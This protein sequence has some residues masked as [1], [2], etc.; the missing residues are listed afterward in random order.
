LDSFEKDWQRWFPPDKNNKPVR[1]SNRGC[2][3]SSILYIITGIIVLIIILNITKGLYSEWLWFDSLNYSSVFSTVLQTRLTIFFVSAIVFGGF[4]IG[5][6]FLAMRLSPKTEANSFIPWEIVNRSERTFKLSIIIGTL[7]L[8]IIF[9]LVAQAKWQIILQFFNAQPFSLTDPVFFKDISFYIFSLPF[10]NFVR[11]WLMGMFILT[12]L[13][14]CGI[15]LFSYLVQR[16]KFDLS[17]PVL[18][19]ASSLLSCVLALFAWGYW[20]GIWELVFS[21]RGAVFGAG[22]ADIHAQL[23]AQWI[24]LAIVVICI[25]VIIFSAIRRN[26]RLPLYAIGGWIAAT[27]VIGL[28][29][30]MS[31]KITTIEKDRRSMFP[32]QLQMETQA[33]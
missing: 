17:V 23:P 30:P 13:G 28:I 24:L 19:H 7:V 14:S 12:L 1:S 25:F 15:Y 2:A 8:S 27:I 20:L 18:V 9:G 21:T 4:L 33:G 26:L 32:A 22:Y 3:L 31:L 10:F 11:G 29:F 5:N 6:I 16:L